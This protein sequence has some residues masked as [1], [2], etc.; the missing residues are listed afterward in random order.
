MLINTVILF[1]RDTLPIFLLFSL[2]LAQNGSNIRYL[3][4]G[5]IAGFLLAYVLY[6]N[7]SVVSELADGGG[8]ELIKTVTLISVSIALCEFIAR[9]L[10]GRN[11]NTRLVSLVLVTGITFINAIHFYIYIIAYWTTTDAG[12]ALLLGN[13]IGIGISFSVSVLLFVLVNAAPF[14]QLKILFLTVFLAGQIASIAMLL[15]QINFLPNQNRLWDT[16]GW[17]QDDS[18]YGH[19]LNVLLG[20][21]ATPTGAYMLIYCLSLV[22]PLIYGYVRTSRR[23]QHSLNEGAV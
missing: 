9:Q 13:I 3:L 2:L 8:L 4:G 10:S 6:I 17:V 19:F 20:Y 1:I 11:T 12:A 7:L 16:S 18:E 5:T 23:G 21:E 22:L 15:E 14:K